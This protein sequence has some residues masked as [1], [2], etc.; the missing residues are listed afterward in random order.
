MSKH[1]AP[2]APLVIEH[3]P[4]ASLTPWADNPR[5]ALTPDRRRRLWAIL[6]TYGLVVPLVVRAETGEMIGGHQRLEWA[7]ARK[8]AVVPIVRRAGLT[9]AEAATLAVSLNNEEA[10]GQWNFEKL[11]KVL[12][13][14]AD[15]GID[16]TL[17]GFDSDKIAN[18]LTWNGEDVVR[19][20]VI[21]GPAP[22]V[23]D[24]T[25]G[26]RAALDDAEAPAEFREFDESIETEH[27]CPKCGYEW[28]G[29][30]A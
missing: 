17:T 23:N 22:T 21:G 13:G 27:R 9:D 26:E 1:A 25:G 24:A 3:V 19:S 18:L 30:Q 8:L 28:S 12:A 5:Q 15:D 10:S 20:E 11:G 4:P 7:T 2:S 6:D 29:K 14:I 16:A